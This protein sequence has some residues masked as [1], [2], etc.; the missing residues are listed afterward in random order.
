[1]SFQGFGEDFLH[2]FQELAENNERPWFQ[3]NKKR[4]ETSVVEPLLRFIEAM[5]PRLAE[6]SS[7]IRADPRRTGGSM[8]RIYRDTRFSKDKTPYKTH[9]AAHFRHELGKNAHAPGY[10]F[11][12][13]PDKLIIGAGIWRPDAEHLLKIRHAIADRP[14]QWMEAVQHAPFA[15]T[16]RLGGEGLKRPPRGFPSDHPMV[17]DLKRKDFIGIAEFEA[18]EALSPDIADKAARSFGSAKPFMA[19]LCSAL[20]VSF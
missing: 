12:I 16:F 10:Y 17:E 18:V 14:D 13:A 2:F 9:A 4:Y 15:D 6:I 20:E 7:H 3:A 8:F 5:G 19:F 1:M 11:H